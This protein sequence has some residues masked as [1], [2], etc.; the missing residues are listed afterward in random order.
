MDPNVDFSGRLTQG[1]AGALRTACCTPGTSA[2]AS[3]QMLA[4]RRQGVW[5]FEPFLESFALFRK[6]PW[7]GGI[8]EA[9]LAAFPVSTWRG[10]RGGRE[11][12][13][14]KGGGG[15]AAGQGG[16]AVGR[17]DS[18]PLCRAWLPVH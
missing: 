4:G 2:L 12:E 13:E 14:Q 15:E 6:V 10:E 5:E 9:T 3:G 8:T 1:G 18:V 11:R 16:R 17:L 7:A